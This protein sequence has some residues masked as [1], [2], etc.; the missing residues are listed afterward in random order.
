MLQYPYAEDRPGNREQYLGTRMHE[1][2]QDSGMLSIQMNDAAA[3]LLGAHDGLLPVPPPDGLAVGLEE[4]LGRGIVRR[5]RVL[6]WAGSAGGAA[7]APSFSPD[8]TGWEC[9][10]SSFHLEDFVPVGVAVI[11]DVPV[12][13]EAAQRTLLI[14]G[15]GFGIRFACL[16]RD[17]DEP[18]PVRCIIGANGTNATFRFHQIREGERWNDPDL[19]SYNLDKLIVIDIVPPVR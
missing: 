18:G 5:E 3:R 19:D 13:S 8:L 15:L 6:T 12:I 2:R 9:S 10:D 7:G 11:D 1:R 16:V 4:I 17:L 14:Q